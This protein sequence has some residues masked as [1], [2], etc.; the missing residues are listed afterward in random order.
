MSLIDLL[1]VKMH[2]TTYHPTGLCLRQ[3]FRVS[4]NDDNRVPTQKHLADESIL[5][6]RL[7]L[8]LAFPSF[9]YLMATS[10]HHSKSANKLE[11]RKAV[12]SNS[13]TIGSMI[14]PYLNHLRQKRLMGFT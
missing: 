9:W 7:S 10:Q 1:S 13:K 12:V 6:H 2:D 4:K 14:S 8:L 3:S 5:V 11:R